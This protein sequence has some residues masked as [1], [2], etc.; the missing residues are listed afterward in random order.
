M[1]TFPYLSSF[2]SILYE[3]PLVYKLSYPFC[4]AA[5]KPQANLGDRRKIPVTSQMVSMPTSGMQLENA[6]EIFKCIFDALGLMPSEKRPYCG[7]DSIS[8]SFQLSQLKVH[9]VSSEESN[10]EDE[11]HSRNTFGKGSTALTL[12]DLKVLGYAI[13]SEELKQISAHAPGIDLS[14]KIPKETKIDISFGDL[15]QI[16]NIALIRLI[17]QICET[18]DFVKEENRF[19]QKVK[20]L[21]AVTFSNTRK[22]SFCEKRFSNDELHKGWDTMFNVLQLYTNDKTTADDYAP[23][24]FRVLYSFIITLV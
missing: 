19:A 1:P 8:G 18:V 14:E 13:K 12:T 17:M 5:S 16:V 10:D 9:I 2:L 23:S 15:T 3:L 4:I 21:E 20:S 11:M 7:E 6:R 24:D 22:E